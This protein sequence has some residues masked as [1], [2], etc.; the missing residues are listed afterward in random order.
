MIE[1]IKK[2][3]KIARIVFYV[4]GKNKIERGIEVD[5]LLLLAQ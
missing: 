4:K 3:K 1:R 2:G 5:I